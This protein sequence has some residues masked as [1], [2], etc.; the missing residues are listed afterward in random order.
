MVAVDHYPE[1]SQV[2]DEQKQLINELRSRAQ[3]I[4]KLYPEYDTDFS[5][6]RWLMGWDNDI[7]VILPKLETAIR[8][9]KNL[10]L[11]EVKVDT[12]EQINTHIRSL[13]D[14]AAYFPGGLLGQDDEGNIIFMQALA[15]AHPKT[16]VKG[17]S[18]NELFHL[19]IAE[20]ELSFKLVR[21]MEEKTGR[22][23][24]VKIIMD[25]DGFNKDL[26]YPATLKIYMNLLTVLQD[27]FP[28]FARKIYII[29]PP[30]MIQTVY[31][32]ISPVLSKQTREKVNFLGSDWKDIIL[33][34]LGAHNVY[35]HW[36]GTKESSSPTGD[37]RMGGKVPEKL[38]YNAEDNPDDGE[39]SLFTKISISAR[40][41]ESVTVK[42]TKGKAI[43]WIWKVSSGDLD[44]WVEHE[45]KE[46]FPKWRLSTEFVPEKGQMICPADGEY[47]F[48]FSNK[49]GKIF[50]KDVKY[51]ILPE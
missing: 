40:S 16:L 48:F 24:G 5:L 39:K 8:T 36:G 4:L 31:T 33:T 46:V 27:I 32:M 2:S 45:E 43:R 35:S 15:S 44:F 50:G 6:L 12:P 51:R 19:S 30:M 11:D 41:A 29:N 18:V 20:T 34:E 21:R 13:T 37:I 3:D 26:L 14:C 23:L 28:D 9:L 10:H 47:V 49:H 17:G 38:W 22:K 7:D 25:L 42:G 1:S